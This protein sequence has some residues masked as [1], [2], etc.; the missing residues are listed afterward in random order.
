MEIKKYAYILFIGLLMISTQGCGKKEV[1]KK[2]DIV[3]M[4]K[5]V[6]VSS[7]D[8][9][10]R[11]Y[12]GKV[13]GAEIVNLSFRVA[14]PLMDLKAIEGQKVK[15]GDE[16]ARIDTR[17]YELL[18]EKAKAEYNKINT[19]Y[20][21]YQK[22]YEK[23][24]VALSVLELYRA[25]QN[26]TKIALENAQSAV[27]DTVLRAPFD[28][29]VGR[30][31]VDNFQ[32][33]APSTPILSIY[34]PKNIEVVINL[35]EGLISQYKQG[36]KVGITGRFEADPKREFDLA[37]KSYSTQADAAT[38]TYQVTLTMPAP[39]GLTIFPG[40]TAS[41]AIKIDLNQIQSILGVTVPSIAVFPG[42]SGESFV[43]VVDTDKLVVHKRQVELGGVTGEVSIQVTTGLK[44][45]ERIVVAGIK[46]LREGMQVKLLK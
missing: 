2:K 21:R 24:A 32:I 11:T 43:W 38:R 42:D 44:D 16:L 46:H 41:V 13:Q 36:L 34:N 12:P 23:D 15:E 9:F 22:L 3:R 5:T 14:G 10:N 26:V 8:T 25:K 6:E 17:D 28:G 40:M 19:D 45:G 18:V 1:K 33:V 29:Q 39:E 31:H 27:K 20:E 4:V 7:N 37:V 35:P 30:V